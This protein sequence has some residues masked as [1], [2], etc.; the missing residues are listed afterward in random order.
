MNNRLLILAVAASLMAVLSCSRPVTAEQ[1]VRSADRDA[2][3][4]Y[5]FDVDMSDSLSVY[6]ISLIASFACIDRDFSSFRSMPLLLMWE[7]P[8]GRCY[9]GSAVLQRKALRDSS[10]YDKVFSDKLGERLSPVRS[11]MWKLYV[12]APDDS[13]E[14]YMMTGMGIRVD[15]KA[16]QDNGTR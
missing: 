11:G 14:K 12:K 1:F 6:D 3:G 13:L 5:A 7:S 8:D 9:E 4:R 10:Y 2:Y 15:R 16:I